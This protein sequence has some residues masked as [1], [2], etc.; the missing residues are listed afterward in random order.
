[1]T[2]AASPDAPAPPD[3]EAG[4]I[5][6]LDDRRTGGGARRLLLH[7][8]RVEAVVDGALA[9]RLA[10]SEVARVRLTVEPAG[11]GAQI[12]CRVS[13]AG[14]EIAFGSFTREGPGRW[15]NNAVA[16][17]RFAIALHEALIARGSGAAFEEG[18]SLGLRLGLSAAGLVMLAGAVAF[19]GWMALVE[20]SAILA[21]A[22]LPFAAIGG[23]LAW[24]FRPGRPA[25]YDP[26]A[27]A[28]SLRAQETRQ[29]G[30]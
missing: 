18:H 16:F 10:L 13:G 25:R 28:A 8:D 19:T 27:M 9:Q 5:A 23:M 29:A 11:G 30:G 12:V 6:A 15:R 20:E 2:D 3:D 4:P 1:M 17:R 7:A 14:R 22:G 21:V 24:T 26:A